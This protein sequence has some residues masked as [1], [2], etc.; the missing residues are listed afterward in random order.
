METGLTMNRYFTFNI[1]HWIGIRII[2]L[3]L[4]LPFSPASSD[5]QKTQYSYS[6]DG[7]MNIHGK[8]TF[9]LGLYQKPNQPNSLESLVKT[10]FN[11]INLPADIGILDS[12]KA[13]G[14]N[15][16]V[17]LGTIDPAKREESWKKIKQSVV[18][19][20]NHPSILA[21]ELA[22]E[23][24]YTWNSD[25]LRILP[26]IMR[27]TRDSV[28]KADPK[29][30][31]YLN[32]AS[33]NLVETMK[34]YNPSND[35]T[36][37]DIYPVIPAGIKIMY[38]LN[39]DGKQ[40]DLPNTTLSQVGDYVDKMRQVCGP[41]RPLLM[42]LQGFAWEMLRPAAERENSKIHYPTYEELWFMSWD[43][44]LHGANGLIWWGTAFTPPEHAFHKDLAKV[45]NNL[46]SLSNLLSAPAKAY[47]IQFRY[48]EMGHSISKGI[49]V[50]V[51]LDGKNIWI[52]TVNTERYPV[53]ADIIVPSGTTKAE[54]LFENRMVHFT[55]NCL[56][57]KYEPYEVHLYKLTPNN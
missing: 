17:T 41:N 15:A 52:F 42:V 56:S 32:H 43:A 49:E 20:K 44:I 19:L 53:K 33:V 51:K 8:R 55:N 5:A 47:P 21:Y 24:A 29:H 12:A 35:I 48:H 2:F 9:L 28:K 3:I 38:A 26:S 22:D 23:P 37:C 4:L 27:E 14:M 36:A 31:I 6:A 40:G 57:E 11:L 39:S 16:W 25:Q 1:K 13:T 46:S 10:G 54:V 50:M 30:L 7:M 18:L 45:V 34:Q